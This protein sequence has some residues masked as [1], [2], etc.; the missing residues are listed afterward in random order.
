MK[1]LKGICFV[2]LLLL[3]TFVGQGRI[4]AGELLLRSLR[5]P[6]T[7][8]AVGSVRPVVEARLMAQASGRILSLAVRAGDRVTEGQELAVMED[9]VLGLKVEQANRAIEAAQADSSRA[10]QGQM[11][12]EAALAQARDEFQ[13]VKKL[14]ADKA[15]TPQRFEQAQAAFKGAEAGVAQ[16]RYGVEA[17]M[18]TVARAEAAK[19]EAEVGLG[20]TRLEAPMAGVVSER[21]VDPGDLAWPGRPLLLL[22]N[23]E[24]MRIE[25][26]VP[27]SLAASVRE[28]QALELSVDALGGETL[29]GAVEEI[30]PAAD[31]L[32]RTVQI[33]VSLPKDARLVS[34]MFGRVRIPLG[35][36]DA[37]L[38]PEKAFR[39][40]GQLTMVRVREGQAWKLRLVRLGARR[41]DGTHEVLAGLAAGDVLALEE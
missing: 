5:L 30:A 12:A 4:Q 28:G 13:R 14:L 8:E 41:A 37:L 21:M 40:V 25:A 15:A 9:R 34:G 7:Y 19:K 33:K 32:S 17:A 18:A 39:R 27:E 24:A 16:A 6:V 35:E 36:R 3:V 20:Y 10:R 2:S 11:A 23:P 26:S 22:M 1:S 38:L 29:K 31:P